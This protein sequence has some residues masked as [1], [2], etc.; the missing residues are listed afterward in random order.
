M[1]HHVLGPSVIA[2]TSR[3]S[4]DAPPEGRPS[5]VQQS[6]EENSNDMK[7]E[8]IAIDGET[9]MGAGG[10]QQSRHERTR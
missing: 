4:D 3:R 6:N 10:G 1:Y 9:D 8:M 5:E 2:S 7:L